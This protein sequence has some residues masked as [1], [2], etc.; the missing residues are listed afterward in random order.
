MCILI[1]TCLLSLIEFRNVF[2]YY[3]FWAAFASNLL[4][5]RLK[6][7]WDWLT[8]RSSDL[9]FLL[10]ALF[11]LIFCTFMVNHNFIYFILNLLINCSWNINT[12]IFLFLLLFQFFFDFNHNLIIDYFLLKNVFLLQNLWNHVLMLFL[13]FVYLVSEGR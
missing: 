6:W 11:E 13:A 8:L 3:W 5:F 7:I 9:L 10:L 12:D 4:L 1:I 2:N